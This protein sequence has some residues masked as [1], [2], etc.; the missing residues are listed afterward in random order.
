MTSVDKNVNV[1]LILVHA[2][3]YIQLYNNYYYNTHLQVKINIS[4]PTEIWEVT[5]LLQMSSLSIWITF[6]KFIL[7]RL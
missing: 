1:G 3:Q 2:L 4:T 5:S 7:D 6:V